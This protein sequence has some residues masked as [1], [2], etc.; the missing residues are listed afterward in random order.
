MPEYYFYAAAL[1][2]YGAFGSGGAYV[3]GFVLCKYCHL[4]C[5]IK[6]ESFEKNVPMSLSFKPIV[7]ISI[8]LWMCDDE[9]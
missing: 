9:G 4:T 5:A 6:S 1:F 2:L 8:H 3:T 7:Y